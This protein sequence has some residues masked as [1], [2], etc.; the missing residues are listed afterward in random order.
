MT[1]PSSASAGCTR[2]PSTT[3]STASRYWTKNYRT[4][5]ELA[6]PDALERRYEYYDPI[7]TLPE[8]GQEWWREQAPAPEA[9]ERADASVPATGAASSPRRARSSG[10]TGGGRCATPSARVE[11]LAR[12]RA[13][14]RGRA[15]RVRGDGRELFRLGISPYYLSLIDRE[16]PFCPVRMQ[17]IP[18]AGPR[19]ASGRASCATRSGEDPTGPSRPSSTSTRTGCCFLALDSCST[20]CRHCT[21]RR[22]TKGGEAELGRA[23]RGPRASPT[24]ARTPRCATCSSPAAIRSC[25]STHGW[26]RCSATLRAIPHVEMIRIG[27]RVPVT[28]P[29][30]GHRG[31][32]AAAPPA[33]AALRRH[34]LQPPEG[35]DA[36]RRA[37]PASAWWTTAC[38]W[39]TSRC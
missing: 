29:D 28:S 38:R 14:D 36:P 17:A 13:A 30:A 20:Y 31:A 5:I 6:D 10:T 39:R 25:S 2:W 12:L 32:G 34:P 27:T 9:I 22:I 3:A 37:P 8:S 19:R 16:H 26:R 15:A 11:Q 18:D 4:G 35:A 7:Y 33:R 23:R 21:R 1:C 24:S